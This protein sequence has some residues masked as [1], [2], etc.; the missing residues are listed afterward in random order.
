MTVISRSALLPYAAHQV[1]ELVN[2]VEAYPAF[3]EGC[4]GA[5][6]LRREP[7]FLDA[8]LELSR[9]GIAQSFSTRNHLVPGQ[10]ITL[11]LLEGPFRSFSGSWQFRALDTAA[12][13]LCLDMEFRMASALLGAAASRLFESVTNELVGAVARRARDLYG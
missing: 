5:R 13:K 11:E 12:C 7:K 6:V 9:G 8:R 3:M 4:V 10:A 2:D 1:Y